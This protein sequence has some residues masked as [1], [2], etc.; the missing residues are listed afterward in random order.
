MSNRTAKF[1]SAI[2]V[3]FLAGAAL[4]TPSRGATPAA[5]DCLAG[6]KDVAPQGSHWYYHIEHPS[7]R[8]CWY[9]KDEHERLSQAAP[10]NSSPSAQPGSPNAETAMQRSI[11]DAHAELPAPQTPVEQDTSLA[12]PPPEA[13]P[14]ANAVGIGNGSPARAADANPQQSVVAWRWPDPSAVNSSAAAPTTGNSAVPAPAGEASRPGIAA[15]AAADSSPE[16]S[17]SQSGPLRTLLMVMIGALSLAGILAGAIFKFVNRG[18][19]TDRRAIW[20]SI[21]SDRPSPAPYPAPRLRGADIPRAPRRVEDPDDRF[22]EMLAR[23]SR[24]PTS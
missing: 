18:I 9:L 16:P 2:F 1:A 4:S 24:N 3:S 11:A 14:T 19:R 20:D 21:G 22:A 5:D 13:S 23:L 8:H 7:K 6:P 12:T 15:L 17:E 10:P